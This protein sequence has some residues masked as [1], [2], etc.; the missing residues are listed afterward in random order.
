[1]DSLLEDITDSIKIAQ[2]VGDADLSR[3]DCSADG[4]DK[5]E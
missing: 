2:M 1:M 5:L 4:G 3:L